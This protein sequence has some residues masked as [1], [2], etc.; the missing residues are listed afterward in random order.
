[1]KTQQELEPS[2]GSVPDS[3]LRFVGFLSFFDRYGTA[4]ML[5]AL[6]LGTSLSFAQAVQLIASYALFYAIGQ[7][8]WGVLSDRFGRLAILR[9]ALT[10]AGLSAIASILFTGFIPLLIAR[11]LTGLLFG[12]LYPTL[13]T[14]LG[15]T[16]TG[17]E[18]ARGLS[19]LQI[20]SSLGTTLATLASGA[21]ATYVDWRLVFA[22]P[23]FGCAAALFSLRKVAEPAHSRAR[24]NFR[25]AVRPMN[26]AL[27]AIVFL[28]GG[29]LMGPLTYIVP[30]LQESGVEI[31][32]AGALGCAF[33][34]GVILGARLMR[35]LVAR[36]SRTWL[37]GGGGLLLSVAFLPSALF[38]S[39]ASYTV[40]AFFLGAA[41]AIMH[42]SMQGWATD[43]SPDA[44]AT[45]VSLFVFALFAGA[46]VAT[47]LTADLAQHAQYGQ[48]FGIGLVLSFALVLLATGTHALWRR[49][50]P[51]ASL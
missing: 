25:A 29:L 27:Y 2:I 26:L 24:F 43:I 36:F 38:P 32:L 28:E 17:V 23:A 6:S 30:A 9:A 41:N 46:S 22:L 42:S 33:A 37:I 45:T 20:Y 10:G 8:I 51:P 35:K 49:K 31:G 1:M 50:N 16:R 3:A 18:R 15:D 14:L 19:D 34:L 13:M 44:R 48:I 4:P 21:V 40:T 7:P 5:V 12:A 11:S 39:P 47:Y